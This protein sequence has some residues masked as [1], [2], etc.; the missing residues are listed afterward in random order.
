MPAAGAGVMGGMYGGGGGDKAASK[1]MKFPQLLFKILMDAEKQRFA[2][3]ISWAPHG[4]AML[5]HD[6]EKFEQVVMPM[7][8]SHS[9]WKSFRRYVVCLCFCFCVCFDI[10]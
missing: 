9:K 2:H 1:A 4:R 8:F 6:R 5:I 3:I 10:S 7:Y